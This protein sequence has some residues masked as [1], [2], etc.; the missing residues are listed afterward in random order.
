[1]ADNPNLFQRLTRL[2]RSGPVVKRNVLKRQDSKVSTAFETFRK[3]Q[4]QV[5]S[6]A[7]SAYGTY[8]RMARYS[9]FSEMEY[10]PEIASALDIYAEES[11]AADENG[12]TLHI[13][14]ENSKIREILTEL[15]YDTLNV[16]FNLTAWVRNLVKYGDFFLFNDVHPDYGVINAYPLPIS[17][18]EREEGFDEKDPMAVRFRWVTQGNQVLENWQISHMRLLGND[19]FLPYGSSVLEPARRIWRQLILLEDAMLVYRIV[20]APERRV[21]KIDVGNVPP[22]EISNYMEQAQSSLKRASVVDKSTGKVDLRYNPLSVDE[23]YFIPVRGADSGTSIDTL[24]GGTMAGETNDV[25]YI[26]KKLFSALKI[27]KAYLGYDEGLGAKATLSQEDI[28]FSRTIARIQRTVLSELNKIAIVHLYCQGFTD[29]D[30][31]DFSLKLSNPST[32]AQQQKLEL[33]R[34]RFEVATSALG[35]PGLVDRNWVQKNIMRLSDEE[36]KAVRKGLVKD[37]IN[38]LE[39]ESTQ[40]T[41]AEG[42]EIN[43]SGP[44]APPPLPGIDLAMGAP[45]G[46]E[47][48]ELS[49]LSITDEDAP[50]RALDAITNYDSFLN[51]EEEKDKEAKEDEELTEFEQWQK[52]YEKDY[53]KKRSKANH[54]HKTG[55]DNMSST[56][57]RLRSQNEPT[58]MKRN[59]MDL[60]QSAKGI[61]QEEEFDL[62]E[63]LDTQV[64]QNAKLTNRI[65]STLQRFDIEYG[66]PAHKGIIISENNSS[67]KEE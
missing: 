51:E 57:Q 64:T 13:Y 49:E 26:Q 17:E 19:A 47:P 40:V 46:D 41:A 1:M 53:F 59:A 33:F 67:D 61:L 25:E 66:K 2:F 5:Y 31:L 24:G 55:L 12:K 15:F 48:P 36:I 27:P 21:F 7:M 16:E 45:P 10:T 14:S 54:A 58:G 3:N 43:M 6:A 30:L 8:D 42:P 4:S 22:E 37:K 34:T 23:D 39:I 29:E 65:K 9:D 32:I 60:K 28:R 56:Y 20:R 35:T 52:D 62:S 44:E 18:I 11:V 50:I 63:Y 38:D